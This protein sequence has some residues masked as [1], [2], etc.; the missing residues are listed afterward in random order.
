MST[1]SVAR[2]GVAGAIAFIVS[3]WAV[4]AD[5][6]PPPA[7]P[8]GTP[9]P[10]PV[11]P[12][13]QLN[14][15]PLVSPVSDRPANYGVV[16]IC[17]G[18]TWV[19]QPVVHGVKDRSSIHIDSTNPAKPPVSVRSHGDPAGGGL[20]VVSGSGTVPAGVGDTVVEFTVFEIDHPKEF[21][22]VVLKIHVVECD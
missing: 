7:V 18:S 19:W 22:K 6:V 16:T 13:G 11:R 21:K 8:W 17:K 3:F 14:G 12:P 9:P 4:S 10:M 1:R 2:R 20:E 5:A 15:N